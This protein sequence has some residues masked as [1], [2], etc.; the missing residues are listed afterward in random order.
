MPADH[1]SY[2]R[3]LKAAGQSQNETEKKGW[4]GEVGVGGAKDKVDP[5]RSLL[6]RVETL[7]AASLV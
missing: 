5:R 4:G 3:V 1:I 7:Q 2:V 6:Q